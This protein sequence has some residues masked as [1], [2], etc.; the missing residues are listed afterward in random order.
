[1]VGKS[2]ALLELSDVFNS[3]SFSAVS[4]NRE[5][6]WPYFTIP[7]DQFEKYA[8]R[9]TSFPH[10]GIASIAPIVT[11]VAAWNK[12]CADV[13]SGRNIPMSPN[14]F[15]F[16]SNGSRLVTGTG[17][18]TPLH[19]V[20]PTPNYIAGINGSIVNYDIS[21]DPKVYSSTTMAYN[22]D[23]LVLSGL[24]PSTLIRDSY[25]DIF[26]ATEPLSMLIAPIYSTYEK[27]SYIVG[28]AQ[29]IFKWESLFSKFYGEAPALY[30]FVENTC[31]DSFSFAIQNH[32]VTFIDSEYPT[33]S[34]IKDTSVKAI[35]GLNG[36]NLTLK[37]AQEAG[38]CTYSLTVHP[39]TQFRQ[40]YDLNATVYSVVVG[41]ILVFNLLTFFAFD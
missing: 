22:L 12:Y 34:W 31:G 33:N 5:V 29:S 9:V 38:I 21:S 41:L 4:L 40:E 32:T 16:D 20:Y 35:I 36:G 23:Q 24:L 18:F 30:C 10:N 28:Y 1:M 39:S 11:D 17:P 15:A 7:F 13:M 37:E 14:M 6:S 2:E 19:H 3:D 25:P 27:S 26:D 8:Q